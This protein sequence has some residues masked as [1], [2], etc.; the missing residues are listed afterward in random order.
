M[1]V[2]RSA[3]LLPGLTLRRPCDT[4]GTSPLGKSRAPRGFLFRFAVLFCGLRLTV[5]LA[6]TLWI[7]THIRL[8]VKKKFSSPCFRFGNRPLINWQFGL[9]HT[10][11]VL[12][13][14]N[15]DFFKR[16]LE[17]TRIVLFSVCFALYYSYFNVWMFCILG[18][19]DQTDIC[20]LNL[21]EMGLQYKH[22]C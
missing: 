20:K 15:L 7:I 6:L 1:C 16:I 13:T 18:I 8:F 2:K 17:F 5:C 19:W 21:D 3:A 10:P 22:T 14:M 9:Y 12:S 11:P 4:S